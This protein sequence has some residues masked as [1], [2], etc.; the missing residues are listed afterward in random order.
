MSSYLRT[1]LVILLPDLTR[2][3]C[4]QQEVVLVERYV[5]KSTNIEAVGQLWPIRRKSEL[6]QVTAQLVPLLEVQN[7]MLCLAVVADAVDLTLPS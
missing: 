2:C 3:R 4:Y 5:R 6:E 7:A 1:R